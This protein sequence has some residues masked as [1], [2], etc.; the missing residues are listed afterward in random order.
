MSWIHLRGVGPGRLVGNVLAGLKV[1][2]LLH[3]HRAR[4]LDRCRLDR[5]LQQERRPVRRAAWLLA[6]IPVMFTYSGWNAAAYVAEEIRDPGRNVPLALAMGTLA[7]IA[8]YCL[9]NLLYLYVLPV[10]Q[11][12]AVRGSVLD[13][14]ADRLLGSP[15]RRR[16]GH[17]LDHQHR[18]EHQRDEC[19]PGRA[20][21]T[22][23]RATA[24]SCRAAARIHPRYQHAGDVDHR[25]GDLERPAGAVG[26]RAGADDLHRVRGRA[27]CRHRRRVAVRAS[28]ARAGRAAAVPR[29]GAIPWRP[30]VFTIASALIVA[31]A[32]WT[33]LFV[34][35]ATGDVLG[36]GGRRTDRHRPRDSDLLRPLREQRVDVARPLVVAA[37]AALRLPE[38]ISNSAG[39]LKSGPHQCSRDT[40]DSANI[41]STHEDVH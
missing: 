9:L 38:Q 17:R 8:I 36:P 34:P 1:S 32:L 13:V 26:Q 30:A 16:D 10:E 4:I 28:R 6:L 7:V 18:G 35:M 25:A 27:V 33:D 11:L 23:W 2:A 22:R 15:R 21:T 41:G 31:N 19:S 29:A 5:Q 37:R 40:V 12:A 39:S 14:I 20:S 24:C 3:L